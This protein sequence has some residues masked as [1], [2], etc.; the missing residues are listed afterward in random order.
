M[1]GTNE[2]PAA[3]AADR[4]AAAVLSTLEQAAFVFAAPSPRPPAWDGEVLV[5]RLTVD[6]PRRGEL[7]LVA[8]ERC[9]AALAANLL[10]VDRAS[11]ERAADALGE[12]LNV[13]AG[14]ELLNVAAGVF[15]TP[16]CGADADHRLGLPAVRGAAPPGGPAVSLVDEDGNRMDAAIAW[17]AGR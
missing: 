11:A 3:V 14:G 7:R 9:A 4:L 12:L 16:A 13:A 15:A 8:S 5:A 1:I 2:A 6:G 17:E 10:G